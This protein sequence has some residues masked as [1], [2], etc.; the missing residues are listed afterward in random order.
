METILK[1]MNSRALLTINSQPA[2][3]GA[4]SE[5]T[6]VGWG[7][8]KGYVYQK[9]Y[10]EFFCSP[11][12]AAVVSSTFE[13]FPSLSYMMT[14]KSGLLKRNNYPQDEDAGVVAVTWGVFPCREVQQP[15]IVSAESF[16]TWAPE[17][18]HL[19]LAPYR[20]VEVPPTIMEIYNRWV[21]INVVDNEFT[22]EN[23]PLQTAVEELCSRIAPL[24]CQTPSSS[25]NTSSVSALVPKI[26]R[27]MSKDDAQEIF[28]HL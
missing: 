16:E 4:R 15:T 10:L 28:K 23:I 20:N 18:F 27:T 11:E 21:L 25:P 22:Q 7:P 19:W 8:L 17:A 24:V 2:V 1:P 26:R 9:A 5:N 12:N 6:L 14:D 3:N 13:R